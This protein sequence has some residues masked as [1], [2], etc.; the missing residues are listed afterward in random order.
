MLLEHYLRNLGRIPR[1]EAA[2]MTLTLALVLIT[3]NLAVGVVAGVLLSA[4]TF[5]HQASRLHV[6]HELVGHERTYYVRGQLFFGSAPQLLN[7]IDFDDTAQHVCIDLTAAPPWDHTAQVV[8]DRISRRLRDAG[9]NVR[10][11]A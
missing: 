3:H 6:R 10:V 11:S 7:A 2:I 5:A 4:I 1:A 8:I 9:K